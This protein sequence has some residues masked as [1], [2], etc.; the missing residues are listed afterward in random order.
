[1]NVRPAKEKVIKDGIEYE[2]FVVNND[3]AWKGF[4]LKN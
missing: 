2:D 3:A 1:M 4:N